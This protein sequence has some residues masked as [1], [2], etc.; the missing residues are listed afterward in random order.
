ME[1][2][3][4]SSELSLTSYLCAKGCRYMGYRTVPGGSRDGSP[5]IFFQVEGDRA[6]IEKLIRLFEIG[7]DSCSIRRYEEAY[8]ML[9]RDLRRVMESYRQGQGVIR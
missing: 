3:F 9:R 6:E 2:V 4:E 1:P 7:L 8:A 5:R